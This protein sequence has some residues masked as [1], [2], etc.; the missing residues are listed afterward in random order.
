[1]NE[2]KTCYLNPQPETFATHSFSTFTFDF[3]HL[4]TFY[5]V[6]ETNLTLPGTDKIIFE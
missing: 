4:F 3:E 2:L 6:L 1:M 5:V